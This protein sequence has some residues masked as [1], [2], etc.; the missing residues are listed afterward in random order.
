MDGASI[1]AGA[2]SGSSGI[3]VNLLACL[4]ARAFTPSEATA[5]WVELVAQRR[6]DIEENSDDSQFQSLAARMACRQD[7]SRNELAKWD[8]S[9]RAWLLSADEVKKVEATQ[10]KLIVK[11]L[12]LFTSSV[13]DTYASILDVWTTAM[14]SLQDL[15]DGM[16]Q[17][18]SKGALL[19]G[20]SAWHIYPD[21]NVIGPTA[22]VRFKDSLVNPGGIITVGLSASEDDAGAK[23]S[24]LLSHLRYYGD[25]VTVSMPAEVDS[26][27]IT[28]EQLLLVAL[29]S[30]IGSWG[31]CGTTVEDGAELFI[32]LNDCLGDQD[33]NVSVSNL[34]WLSPLLIA[35]KGFLD[36]PQGT[37]RDEASHLIAYGRRNGQSFLEQNQQ[38]MEPIFGLANPLNLP[39]LSTNVAED[40]GDGDEDKEKSI[41]CLRRLASQ[42]CLG[43]DQCIIRYPRKASVKSEHMYATAIPI[44]RKSQER[45]PERSDQAPLFHMRWVQTESWRSFQ[46]PVGEECHRYDPTDIESFKSLRSYKYSESG[47]YI[48]WR[49]APRIFSK[50]SRQI[51][52]VGRAREKSKNVTNNGNAYTRLDAS[53]SDEDREISVVDFQEIVCDIE[54]VALF[55][56]ADVDIEKF[57]FLKDVEVIK[58]LRSGNLKPRRIMDLLCHERGEIYP[59]WSFINPEL[60]LE[61]NARTFTS[62][63]TS[64]VA[65]AKA[66]Q[67]YDELPGATVSMAITKRPL[68][69]AGWA[70]DVE[71][72]RAS[73]FGC[74]ANFETGTLDIAP[75]AISSVMA[76]SSGNS[77]FVANELIQDPYDG[78]Y[79][80][81]GITRILGNL[82]RPGVVMLVPPPA[83]RIAPRDSNS[84]RLINHPPFKGETIDSFGDTSL[85]LSFTEYEISLSVRVGVI[86]AD[87]VMLESLI[88]VYDRDKWIADLD[89]LGSLARKESDFFPRLASHHETMCPRAPSSMKAA[90]KSVNPIDNTTKRFVAIDN[91]DELLDPPEGLGISQIGVI[92]ASDSW[93][94]RLATMSVCI[95]RTYRTTVLPKQ[96]VCKFCVNRV[97]R[98]HET[99]TQIMIL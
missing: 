92:R 4:L 90:E 35:A 15:I 72:N 21:L 5:I 18:I 23:W 69:L 43:Y 79:K 3:A 45:S 11:D 51:D 24:L 19:L 41:E 48:H 53:S 8:A 87:A 77:I 39:A 16:P 60:H 31:M 14:R 91:W 85:H 50:Y 27:R 12:G 83:P 58:V 36:S 10:F 95:Q 25:P 49:N 80:R 65:L 64:L 40:S 30:V 6:R 2:S 71:S 78:S 66:K 13:G 57:C 86:D 96:P 44:S 68:H 88:S 75:N 81:Q 29:G 28:M 52:V 42:C 22:Y 33:N 82:G 20:I 89:V 94:A 46:V 7:L 56:I 99:S 17:K 32:A 34:L 93:Q 38:T 47:H 98:F 61:S 67:L 74:I 55:K 9:A 62:I 73:K 76:M 70:V 1:C 37:R 54:D 59:V 97:I 84:W 26:S 63:K